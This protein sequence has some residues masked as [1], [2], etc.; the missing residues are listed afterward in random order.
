MKISQLEA[1]KIIN[2]SGNWAV[3]CF[4]KTSQG[5]E[6]TASVPQGISTGKQER[7]PVEA[8]EAINQ[9]EKE[10]FPQ[11]T[12]K[13]LG[14][15]RLDRILSAGNWGTNATLAV[16]AA[17][18]KLEE[19]EKT[20]H[21]PKMMMLIFEGKSHGNP[22]LGFQEFMAIVDEIETGIDFYQTVKKELVSRGSL[23]TV[24]SE[25]A[26]SP[27]DFNDQAIFELMQKIGVDKIALDTAGNENPPTIEALLN[28]VQ[29]YPIVSIEDPFPEDQ[30]EQWQEFFQKVVQINPEILI[31]ADDLV[32]T[33]TE[34]IRK[35]A[36]DRLFNSVII[37]PNQQGTVSA[38]KNALV[39]AKELGLKTIVSHR[40][41]ETNDNWV[42]DFAIRFKADFVKFGAPARGERVAKYNRLLQLLKS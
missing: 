34:K 20:S 26:F 23:I 11:I 12:G 37:K 19:V 17:F 31:V 18:F 24:G 32:V 30:P 28:L 8:E 14:Q 41:E 6:T 9:I 5:K 16:S 29:R 27:I 3:E 35:G 4:L 13:E 40:G 2:S 38:A 10:I 21:L 33:N 15:E 25:G 42:A 7:A 22:K 36:Q 39:T 1:T